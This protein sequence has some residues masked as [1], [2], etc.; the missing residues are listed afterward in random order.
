MYKLD[1]MN[2]FIWWLS[3]KAKFCFVHK[4]FQFSTLRSFAIKITDSSLIQYADDLTIVISFRISESSQITKQTP[5]RDSH[6]PSY[7]RRQHSQKDH[8]S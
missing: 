3:R 7:N 6:L 2:W 4:H 8:L 5:Y 1:E